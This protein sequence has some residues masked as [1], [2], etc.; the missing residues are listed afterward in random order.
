MRGKY[1]KLFLATI[2][3]GAMLVMYMYVETHWLKV[4]HVSIVSEDVP[5]AFAGK[6]IVFIADI[7]HGPYYSIDRAKQLVQ[8]INELE[9][10][11]IL[12]GGDYTHRQPKYIEPLF[13]ELKKLQAKYGKF[14]VIGNHD[15]WESTEITKK[16]LK[17][18]NIQMCDN[19]SY[20]IKIGADSIKVGGVGD[21]WEDV[22]I[23]DSTTF[24]L[25]K[26]DFSILLTH[27]PDYMEGLEA[28]LIDLTLAG[29]THGGQVT[30][31]GLY[32]PVQ[33]TRYGNKYRYGLKHFGNMQA[34][35]TSGVGTV[36]P[37]LRFFCR[38][39]IVLIELVKK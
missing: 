4:T 16:A 5:D 24:D 14:G 28:P 12:L 7:H 27:N 19:K 9:P 36:T 18:A 8:T 1:K 37:P 23:L 10:D 3:L 21:L 25:Q 2:I 22:Q 11:I 29:H 6:K 34:Y 20:W 39:E 32:A 30:F 38:P 33:S 26:S 13:D 35:I 17:F 31:F 15:H